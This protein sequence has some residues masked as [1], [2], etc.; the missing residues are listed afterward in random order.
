MNY[1]C[2]RCE[3]AFTNRQG[4]RC[5]VCKTPLILPD[6]SIGNEQAFV[7]TKDGLWREVH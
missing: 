7:L 4:G 5:K 6:V 1:T 3:S 2:P